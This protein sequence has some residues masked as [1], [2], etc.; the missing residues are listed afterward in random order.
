MTGCAR[1]P[2]VPTVMCS[3]ESITN[4]TCP[5]AMSTDGNQHNSRAIEKHVLPQQSDV[6]TAE[7]LVN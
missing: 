6:W 7:G 4:N 3:Q 2:Q 1:V 5:V